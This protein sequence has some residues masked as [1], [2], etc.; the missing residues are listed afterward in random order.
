MDNRWLDSLY[1]ISPGAA[2]GPTSRSAAETAGIVVAVFG[3]LIGVLVVA[4]LIKRTWF[5]DT[6][7][8]SAAE[9]VLLE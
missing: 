6:R 9:R 1:D 3:A 8:S 4:T 7:G 2:D 5:D